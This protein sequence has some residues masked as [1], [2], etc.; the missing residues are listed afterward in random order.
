MNDMGILLKTGT[1]EMELLT[2]LIDG[3]PFGINVAKIKS[4][5]QYNP[6]LMTV[7]PESKTGVEGMF[8]YRN[9]NIPLLDLAK[10]LKN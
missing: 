6:D 1:N 10:I 9:Q 3:Q 5:Q 8:L 7:L 2:V 4:I